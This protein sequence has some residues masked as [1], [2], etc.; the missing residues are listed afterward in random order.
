MRNLV[1][2]PITRRAKCRRSNSQEASLEMRDNLTVVHHGTCKLFQLEKGNR[3]F[4]L[5]ELLIVLGIIM[6]IAALATPNLLAAIQQARVGRAVGDINAIEID[7]TEYQITN[8]SW[9]N[10]LADVGRGAMLDPWG[11]PYQY[12]N[13]TTHTGNGAI[14]QDQFLVPVNTDYDLYS[15]G[16]DG[17]TAAPIMSGTGRD[18]VIRGANGSYVGPASLF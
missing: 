1:K 4:T 6:L 10:T 13:Q 3:G 8:G 16:P 5:V 18:D 12:Y 17:Q 15:M 2:N 14:R 11:N 7:I 9:P